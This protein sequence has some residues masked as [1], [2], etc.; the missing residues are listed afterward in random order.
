[1]PRAM[2]V[3]RMKTR[4]SL[5]S[6]GFGGVVILLRRGCGENVNNQVV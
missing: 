6:S 3:S 5:K 1:M 4:Q 2:S